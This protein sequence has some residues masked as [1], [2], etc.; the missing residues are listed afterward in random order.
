VW[1]SLQHTLAA[2]TQTNNGHMDKLQLI[3]NLISDLKQLGF[4]EDSKLDA[5]FRRAEM[6]IRNIHGQKSKYL[7]DLG[8][9]SFHPGWAPAER[10]DYIKYWK[11]GTEEMMNLFNTMKEELT[12]FTSKHP[13]GTAAAENPASNKVFIVHGRDESM[14]LAVA[15]TLDKLGLIPVILHEQPNKGRTIIEKFT[16]YSDVTFAVVLLSPDDLGRSTEDS[17]DSLSHRAR[18]NVVLELGYFI[19][20]LGRERVLAL[21]K[22]V[23][24]FEMPSDFSGVLY[25]P[26]DDTGRWQFDLVREL[27]AS[28]YQVDANRLV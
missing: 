12:L 4:D 28:H 23:D 1:R 21:F 6:M 17:E 5:L 15:R 18:Q 26:Y 22:P 2:T 19:G 20:K 14:K 7:E 11:S 16:D 24:T 13:Q 10:S 3:E 27:K 8:R 9:I 25:V